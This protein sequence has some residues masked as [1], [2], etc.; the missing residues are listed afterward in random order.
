MFFGLV[1]HMYVFFFPSTFLLHDF[2]CMHFAN[3]PP[4]HNFSNG[5]SLKNNYYYMTLTVYCIFFESISIL[6]TQDTADVR[7]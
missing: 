2:S 7:H 4:P 6:S 1:L 3:Q 5:P